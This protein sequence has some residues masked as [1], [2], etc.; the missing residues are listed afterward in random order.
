MNN[1]DLEYQRLLHLILE[2][3]RVKKNRTGVDT[4]GVFGAQA[5]FNL[6]EGFPLLTTKKMAVKAI[7]HEL[8]WFIRGDTNI[9]YLVDNNCNIW[10]GD[11]YRKYKEIRRKTSVMPD[12]MDFSKEEFIE[13]IKTDAEFAA[14]WGDLGQGTYGQMWR[15]FP[16][17]QDLSSFVKEIK[18]D[19]GKEIQCHPYSPLGI[20]DQLQKVINKLKTNPDDRRMIVSAWHPYWVDHC[21][22]PPCHC[23]FHFNTEELTYKERFDLLVKTEAGL[24]D[25]MPVLKSLQERSMRRIPI[26][27]PQ[28]S[29]WVKFAADEKDYEQEVGVLLDKHNIPRR[30]LNCL[31]YQRSCDFFLGIPFN[32]ASY[33]MLLSMVA[34]VVNMVPGEFVHS[35]GD[36]HLYQ[37][38]IEQAKLQLTREPYPLPTLKLNPKITSLFDFKFEDISIE[39]YQSHPA[40]KGDVSTG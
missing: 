8:L 1:T 2:K 7:T 9:K 14:K 21:A 22:L 28:F 24:K 38:H 32:I 20:V 39:N 3:G 17:Y 34:Q 10:N 37:N 6:A 25:L 35:M 33:A 15:A 13:K 11:C 12:T 23:L 4:I 40:I 30:R 19:D 18:N 31:L 29:H 36:T 16:Y 26:E 5:R 27:D